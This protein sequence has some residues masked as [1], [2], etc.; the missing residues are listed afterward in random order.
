MSPAANVKVQTITINGKEYVGKCKNK[1]AAGFTVSSGHYFFRL[2][3]QQV[4]I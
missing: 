2:G 1:V 4:V 3:M